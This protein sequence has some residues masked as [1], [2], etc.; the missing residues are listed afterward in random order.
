M[1]GA[2]VASSEALSKSIPATRNELQTL[3]TKLDVL[4]K[5]RNAMV[6][7]CYQRAQE[8]GM[9]SLCLFF[10]AVSSSWCY[11]LCGPTC[12]PGPL[13]HTLILSTL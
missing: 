3:F 9:S 10:Y 11:V 8:C 5:E 13:V 12:A 1:H 4:Y 7:G 2:I 6:E